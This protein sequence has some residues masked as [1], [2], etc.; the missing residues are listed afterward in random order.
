MRSTHLVVTVGLGLVIVAGVGIHLYDGTSADAPPLRP[1]G[2]AERCAS[3]KPQSL[4][5]VVIKEVPAPPSFEAGAEPAADYEDEE[6]TTISPDERAFLLQQRFET[7]PNTSSADVV[8]RIHVAVTD[9]L[10]G[11]GSL[12]RVDCRGLECR[13]E[14]DLQDGETL[15][16]AIE[17]IT[18]AEDLERFGASLVY[19][20]PGSSDPVLLYLHGE[21]DS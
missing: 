11:D 6:Q 12:R 14:L 7:G 10:A 2:P 5:R 17:R 19:P 16:A 3:E 13:A 15:Q 1:R 21:R 8:S 18:H 9:A 4:E 20:E